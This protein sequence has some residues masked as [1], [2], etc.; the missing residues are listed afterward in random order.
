MDP[1]QRQEGFVW[2]F[3]SIAISFSELIGA[4]FSY[5]LARQFSLLANIGFWGLVPTFKNET[6]RETVVNGLNVPSEHLQEMV[7]GNEKAV[8]LANDQVLQIMA[9]R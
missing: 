6:V 4:G 7:Q 1:D 3:K 2:L 5:R 8:S 9:N